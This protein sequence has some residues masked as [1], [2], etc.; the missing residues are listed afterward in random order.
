MVVSGVDLFGDEFNEPVAAT[1]PGFG[2]NEPGIMVSEAAD[3]G[4]LIPLLNSL[5]WD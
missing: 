5:T 1:E 3:D 2:F 4:P